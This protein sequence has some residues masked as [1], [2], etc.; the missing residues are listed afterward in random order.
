MGVSQSICTMLPS[1]LMPHCWLAVHQFQRFPSFWLRYSRASIYHAC[2]G[3]ADQAFQAGSGYG[4][5]AS[6]KGALAVARAHLTA[7]LEFCP[8][9]KAGRSSS[10]G[11]APSLFNLCSRGTTLSTRTGTSFFGGHFVFLRAPPSVYSCQFIRQA[12]QSPYIEQLMSFA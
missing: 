4:A 3:W 7:D 6:G 1:C 8:S 2:P 9:G 12:L 5:R 11:D 10:G